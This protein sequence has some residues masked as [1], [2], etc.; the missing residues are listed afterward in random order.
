MAYVIIRPGGL[1]DDAPTKVSEKEGGNFSPTLSCTR[2][3]G[4]TDDAP[5]KV[6]DY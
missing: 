2:P 4:L 3:G 1:T 5:T 6:S